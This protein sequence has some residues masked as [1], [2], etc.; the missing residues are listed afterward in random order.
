[1]IQLRTVK[2]SLSR[3]KLI[4]LNYPVQQPLF[5]GASLVS[6]TDRLGGDTLGPWRRQDHLGNASWLDRREH[7][8]PKHPPS[9]VPGGWLDADWALPSSYSLAVGPGFAASRHMGT[10]AYLV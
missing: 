3:L 10:A 6:S 2:I 8:G 9:I 4:T 1:M 7:S 5:Y